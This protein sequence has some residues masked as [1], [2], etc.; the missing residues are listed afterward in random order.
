MAQPRERPWELASVAAAAIAAVRADEDQIA[1]MKALDALQTA[2]IEE[3]S[4]SEARQHPT[5]T[6]AVRA[7]LSARGLPS[8]PD[9]LVPGIRSEDTTIGGPAGIL[10][11]RVYLPE[12][13]GPFP[14]VLYFHGGGWVLASKELY[15]ASARGLARAADA[16]V[17]S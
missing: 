3:L 4:P 6:D 17:T 1:L 16:I 7:L 2:A 15:D 14:V 9:A 10:A 5:L 13:T 12:G 8:T 11:V